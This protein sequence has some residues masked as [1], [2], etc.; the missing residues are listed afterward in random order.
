M[1]PMITRIQ[2]WGNSYSFRIPRPMAFELDLSENTPVD[3]T[4]EN[5][6][7][8]ASPMKYSL[9]SL[10]SQVSEENLHRRIETDETMDGEVW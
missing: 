1:V 3:L 6:C 9:E 4:V 7:L 5:G 8:V 10:L 2:K